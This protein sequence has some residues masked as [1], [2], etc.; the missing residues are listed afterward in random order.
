MAPPSQICT[1]PASPPRCLPLPECIAGLL[2]QCLHALPNLPAPYASCRRHRRGDPAYFP[3]SID[4]YGIFLP[5]CGVQRMTTD[6]EAMP[7]G[8]KHMSHNLLARQDQHPGDP[9]TSMLW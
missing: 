2:P 7:N 6:A 8:F 1:L 3:P 5:H 9:S 4:R